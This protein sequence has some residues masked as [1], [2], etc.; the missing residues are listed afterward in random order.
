MVEEST[1]ASRTLLDKTSELT[2]LIGKFD[3][4]AGGSTSKNEA[5]TKSRPAT[6]TAL[7]TVSTRSSGGGAQRKAAVAVTAAP[8]SW[9]EF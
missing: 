8:D 4:G 7:K 6:R 1:A 2:A 5:A 3:V 9:E